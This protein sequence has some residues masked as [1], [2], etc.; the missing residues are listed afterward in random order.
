MKSL[1]AVAWKAQQFPRIS[2][3][4]MMADEAE[5]YS[6]VTNFKRL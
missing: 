2:T 6:A 3:Q 4:L 1:I 5:A